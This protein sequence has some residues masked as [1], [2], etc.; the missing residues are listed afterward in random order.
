MHGS[1]EL[2]FLCNNQ[3]I[4]IIIRDFLQLWTRSINLWN[5]VTATTMADIQVLFVNMIQRK[6]VVFFVKMLLVIGLQIHVYF[7]Q[8]LGLEYDSIVG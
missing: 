1:F 2:T 3:L 7:I 4:I 8:G 6:I 5:S